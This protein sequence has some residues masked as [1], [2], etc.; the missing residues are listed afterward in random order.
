VLRRAL[1]LA[2]TATNGR[3]MRVRRRYDVPNA[4]PER[5]LTD[6][7]KT[8]LSNSVPGEH[9]G[10]RTSEREPKPAGDDGAA[11]TWRTRARKG[12]QGEALFRMLIT[13]VVDYAI[14]VLDTKGNVATWNVGAERLNGYVAQEIVGKHFSTFYPDDDVRVG[15]CEHELE[16][17]SKVGRFED[18]GWR[19]RK[20][21]TRF[22]ANV[23]ISAIRE[24]NGTVIGF[25]KVVRDLTDRKREEE[26]RAARLAAEQATKTKDEFLAMLSHELRNPLAP[27]VTALDLI[28]LRGD[29]SSAKEYQVIER[30]VQ[31]MMRLVDDLLDVSRVARGK[32]VLKRR[33]IDVRDV[34]A[35][36]IE[37]A[38]PLFEQRRH[39]LDVALPDQ[40]IVVDGDEARLTQVLAN[41]L[42]N[43]AKYTHAEGH[44]AVAVRAVT[45]RAVIEVRD[46]GTGIDEDLLPR[47]FDL[48]VQGY[49]SA[50]RAGGGLGLGLTLVRSLVHLHGGSV[51][52]HSDG[53]G[54][55]STFTVEL[56]TVNEPVVIEVAPPGP[57]LTHSAQRI[58]IVDD[59]E[60][61]R[62]LLSDLLVATGHEVRTAG[63]GID[64]LELIKEFTPD[65]AILDIG[66]PVMDGYELA[67]RLRQKLKASTLRL[68]SLTGYGQQADYDRSQAA[69][70]D[71]HLVKP[72]DMRRLLATIHE[73]RD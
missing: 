73:I 68:I 43:A 71:R 17:A 63:D 29:N 8:G 54:L 42:T 16:A 59:N 1:C 55:G 51:T 18:E 7:P 65:V 64:A 39:H 21:G 62:S 72:V 58:L 20:D 40:A 31:H 44:I 46:D 69:G 32:V 13:S 25:A 61:A 41:L 28:K 67:E 70:F 24:P 27:I 52:A 10:A 5:N 38:S 36:A 33:R 11:D 2:R 22:W 19:I 6:N 30:Q 47:M 37:I 66:L 14:F 3:K 23:V 4:Q 12:V 60:D 50:E 35:K 9:A 49:Q 56:P 15:K 57:A 45:D 53:I 26:E 34:I 48:F